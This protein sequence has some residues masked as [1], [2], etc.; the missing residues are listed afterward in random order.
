M[1]K[2]LFLLTLSAALSTVASAAT[3]FSRPLPIANLNDA[4]GANRSN[5]AW[6][7]GQVGGADYYIIGDDF[8]L[9]SNT[10]VQTLT[11]W[12]V[13]NNDF[14]SGQSDPGTEFSQIRL[15]GGLASGPLSQISSSYSS[16]LVTYTGGAQYQ[17]AAGGFYPIYALTFNVNWAITGGSLYAFA[18]DATPANVNYTLALHS[19]NAA[20]SGNAQPGADNN[21]RY[22]RQNGAQF[23]FDSL[24]DSG[25]PSCGG[26]DKPTD[27]NVLL[28]DTAV[29][30]PSTVLFTGFGVL[31]LLGLRRRAA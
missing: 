21:F 31:A 24:C 25:A 13:A 27:L 16:Q 26:F 22:Y 19:S 4:A 7:S 12:A 6:V 17:G 29:P 11:V 9:A 8:T 3:V 1:R 2:A 10:T 28:G 18:V 15:Y 14:A 5:V 30:E 23:V 20:L